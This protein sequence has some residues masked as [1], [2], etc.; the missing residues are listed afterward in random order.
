VF[1]VHARLLE[2]AAK[3]SPAKGGGSLT[4][5]PIAEIDAGNLSAYIPTNLISITD[6]QIVLDA[7]LFHEGH[8]PAVDIGT[9]VSRVGG[10]TQAP[11]LRDAAETLRLDYAQFLELEMFTRFGGMSDSR[12]RGKITRGLRIRAV[13][14]Q[15][16]FAPLRL[17]DE[18]ALLVALQE[19]LLDRVPIAKIGDF[20]AE[21]PAW[22]DRTA[23]PIVDTIGR[24]GRIDDRE[25]GELRSA[26][27]ALAARVTPKSVSPK[28]ERG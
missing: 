26:V 27:A 15:P 10:K 17:A 7:R 19:G 12:V 25:R 3:L 5:L 28:A 2:R 16:Q 22:L 21:L 9:S 4:A 8:K 13:L 1:Y 23:K 18:V 11:A 14:T 20:R 6:G 24:T